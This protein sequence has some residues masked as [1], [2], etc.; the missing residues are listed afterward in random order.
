MPSSGE[1]LSAAAASAADDDDDDEGERRE[2]L[3]LSWLESL[4]LTELKAA[5]A[6]RRISLTVARSAN[7]ALLGV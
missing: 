4:I 1:G 7:C 6:E 3:V 2:D 5:R